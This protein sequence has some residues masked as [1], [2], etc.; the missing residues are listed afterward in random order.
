MM[1]AHNTGQI[2]NKSNL[3]AS[4]GVSQPTVSTYIDLLENTF[5][6]RTLQPCYTNLKK[7][8]IKS[9]KI[10]IRDSGLIHSLLHISSQNDLLGHPVYGS[11]WES[12]AL[13]QIVTQL[14]DWTPSF[15]RTSNGSEIDLILEKGLHKLAIEF[16]VNPSQKLSAGFYH[17][18]DDLK[19]EEGFVICPL[20]KDEIYPIGKNI[21]VSSIPSFIEDIENRD[22]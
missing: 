11:S 17:G 15:Y 7:R 18:L 10:F 3:S 16:K 20:A 6:V 8:L 21:R 13:E 19:I 22:S 1:L 5:M 12:Y 9:P 2:L 4:L 14:S